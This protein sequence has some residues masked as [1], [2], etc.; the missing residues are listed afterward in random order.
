MTASGRTTTP[1]RRKSSRID[2]G[3]ARLASADPVVLTSDFSARHRQQLGVPDAHRARRRSCL[4]A[5]HGRVIDPAERTATA[6]RPHARC[7]CDVPPFDFSQPQGLPQAGSTIRAGGMPCCP[8]V[9]PHAAC[10]VLAPGMVT[11]GAV[12]D[13]RDIRLGR[14]RIAA[15]STRVVRGT[16]GW[17]SSLSNPGRL[18][19]RDRQLVGAPAST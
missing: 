18:A 2:P 8:D 10:K 4:S 11:G 16:V 15:G 6:A 3:H 14:T 17:T 13:C 1:P 7:V 19:R 9:A 12:H 5:V